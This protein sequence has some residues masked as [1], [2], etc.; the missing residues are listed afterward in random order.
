MP[1]TRA[2]SA[3]DI[4]ELRA[5][6]NRATSLAGTTRFVPKIYF[7]FVTLEDFD[8]ISAEIRLYASL[9]GV[10]FIRPFMPALLPDRNF[11]FGLF[12]SR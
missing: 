9:S 7:F 8:F 10:L 4:P 2:A 1:A 12:A 11:I 5:C 6:Q 3:K